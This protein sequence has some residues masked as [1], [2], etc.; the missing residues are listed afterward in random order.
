[1]D[2]MKHPEKGRS[3]HSYTEKDHIT[4]IEGQLTYI[5][6]GE[7]MGE[8]SSLPLSATYSLFWDEQERKAL[9]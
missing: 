5:F 9:K 3:D 7:N 6:L 1:M 8:K 4:S 2:S